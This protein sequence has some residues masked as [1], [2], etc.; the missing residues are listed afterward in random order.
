MSTRSIV[1]RP[2]GDGFRGRYVHSDGMP[3][4]RGPVLE[5]L[6]AREG[7]DRVLAVLC[8]EHYG[9]SSLDPDQGPETPYGD[10]QRFQ[11][12]LGWGVAYTD[13]VIDTG[14]L[15]P[16]YQQVT[17]EEWWTWRR[18]WTWP[19]D[20]LSGTEWAYV[21]TPEGNVAVYKVDGYP[22]STATLVGVYPTDGSTDWQKV[23]ADGYALAG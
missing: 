5:R 10:D 22:Q 21:I 18:R 7:A 2:H 15:G 14:P 12:V 16:G 8:D 20:D 6:I 11:V 19:D 4:W 23:Q 9:W 3:T 17:E 1:A 13:T